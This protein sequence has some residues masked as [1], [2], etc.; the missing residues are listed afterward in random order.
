MTLYELDKFERVF[1]RAIEQMEREGLDSTEYMDAFDIWFPALVDE[2]RRLHH[3]L[4]KLENYGLIN[5]LWRKPWGM[6]FTSD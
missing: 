5:G 3:I 2:I 6:E 1:K 4:T